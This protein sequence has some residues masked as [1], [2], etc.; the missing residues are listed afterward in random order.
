M[1]LKLA[2]RPVTVLAARDQMSRNQKFKA[3]T[4]PGHPRGLLATR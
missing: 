2:V 1:R 3:S 4:A